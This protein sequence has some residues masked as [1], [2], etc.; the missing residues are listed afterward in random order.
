METHIL[1]LTFQ[2]C[3]A[4]YGLGVGVVHEF[5][6]AGLLRPAPTPEAVIIDEPDELPRLVRLHH[7]LDLSPEALDVIM[8]M[9]RR[10]VRLQ[11]TLEY[12]KA[13]ARQL[14]NFLRGSSPVLDFN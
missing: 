12:E 8:A 11:A 5:L 2:E 10:L 3:S 13:R 9:R 4:R 7:E 6:Q 14:E 1:T